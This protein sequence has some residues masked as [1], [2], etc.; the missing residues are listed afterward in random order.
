MNIDMIW[1]TVMI[2]DTQALENLEVFEVEGKISKSTEGSLFSY[3]NNCG[4]RFGKRLLQRWVASPLL[5]EAR[6]RA[7]LD[8]VEDLVDNYDFVKSFRVKIKKVQDLERFLVRIYKYS[9]KQQSNACYLNV[10]S[11]DR[12]DEFHNLTQQIGL[13]TEIL[14]DVFTD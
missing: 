11:L 3:L 7:R 13:I 4:T 9:I 14:E 5:N 8:A 10:D 2:L 1:M 12:L 6:L